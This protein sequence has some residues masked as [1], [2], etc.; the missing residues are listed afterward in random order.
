LLS[1]KKEHCDARYFGRH[2]LTLSMEVNVLARI[3]GKCATAATAA[4]QLSFEEAATLP[5][6]GVTALSALFERRPV[7]PGETVLLSM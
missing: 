5:C 3:E 6:A 2:C 4:V 1:P 7:Q